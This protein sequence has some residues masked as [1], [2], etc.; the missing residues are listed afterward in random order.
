MSRPDESITYLKE[1]GYC[2]V[3]MPSPEILPLH[4]LLRAGRKDLVRLGELA[5]IMTPGTNPLPELHSDNAAP[6]QISGKESSS[7][8]IEIGLNILANLIRALGG[9]TLD[10][11][12]GFREA[13]SMVFK[14]GDVR[15]DHVELDR[16][17]Q[18]LSTAA[19]RSDQRAVI[20]ALI[21]DDVYVITSTLKS[22]RFSVTVKNE[23]GRRTALDI[24]VIHKVAGGDLD[25]DTNRA[26]EG[27]VGYEGK[28]PVVFGFQAVQLIYDG[29]ACRYTTF[30][31]VDAGKMAAGLGG[32]RR[33][34]F[35]RLEGGAFFNLR[36]Q[37]V[38]PG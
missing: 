16:L 3:R 25:V 24:P 2:V 30:D 29:E 5:T 6:Y 19:I 15:E 31:P 37:P 20:D 34:V 27:T 17:D 35:L 21:D 23:H 22:T 18:F 32:E 8:K 13:R 33:A 9:S 36:D 12:L 38:F 14:F 11:S 7:M 1:R 26:D 28:T 4:T 10:L